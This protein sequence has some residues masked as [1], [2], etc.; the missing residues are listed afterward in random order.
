MQFGGQLNASGT[1]PND[2][3]IHPLFLPRLRRELEEQVQHL[4][5]ETS[6]LVRV[7]QEDTVIFYARSAKVVRGTAQRH[8]QN[9]VRQLALRHQFA[10]LLVADLRQVQRFGC[11]FMQQRFP[12]MAVVTVHQR[13]F[14]FMLTTEFM[15]Q[16]GRQFQ[17]TGATT[18]DDDFFLWRCQNNPLNVNQLLPKGKEI[19]SLEYIGFA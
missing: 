11:D 16:A 15:A 3:D 6:R 2:S 1:A 13:D 4:V 8:H 5:V 18:H 14:S 17:T 9:I 10:T 7:I 12:Q 19:I